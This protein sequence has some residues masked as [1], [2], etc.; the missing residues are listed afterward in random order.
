MKASQQSGFT[1]IELIAVIVI[2]GILAAAALPKFVDLGSDAR[3]SKLNAAT[4]ALASMAAMAH[5]K[6]LVTSPAPAT[7]TFE[8][9]TVTY[10][11]GYPNAASV[12]AASG[13][14]A[15]DYTLTAAGTTLTVSPV[16]VTTVAN[17]R[18]VYT[19]AAANAAP[20]IVV[21]QTNCS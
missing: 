21:T 12:G 3:K 18:V 7:A 9:T 8:G 14:T 20:S 19:E 4:G 2:L 10:V 6:Y 15:V 11:N 16:G 17:C 1:L 5:S 13:L